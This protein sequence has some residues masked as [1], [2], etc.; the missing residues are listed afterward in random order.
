[1]YA[2]GRKPQLQAQ[3]AVIA[4]LVSAL[5]LHS[6]APQTYNADYDQKND[7]RSRCGHLAIS[8]RGYDCRQQALNRRFIVRRYTVRTDKLRRAYRFVYLSDLHQK[9]Y[10]GG[11]EAITAAVRK[12]KPDFIIA[13]GDFITS[14][15]AA[16]QA[17]RNEFS[18]EGAALSLLSSLR[19]V[20]PV[21]FV[22]GNHE[23]KLET[24]EDEV[25]RGAYARFMT[26]LSSAGVVTGSCCTAMNTAWSTTKKSSAIR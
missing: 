3:A 1:M 15:T 22:N 21:Y 4:A 20:A 17:Y 18:F 9:V 16:E 26:D 13:G 10:P 7:C 25:L 24:S 5:D 2:A 8:F 11:N 12:E 23:E 14:R 19:G 6:E